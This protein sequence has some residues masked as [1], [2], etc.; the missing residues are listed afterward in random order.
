MEFHRDVVVVGAGFAGLRALW[1]LREAGYS[2]AVLE[3]S[4]GIG[5]VWYANRYPGA[6][7]DVESFDYSYSFS[8]E[9]QQEWRWSER[10]ATQPEI[11]R[12]I[13]HVADRFDLRR[14]V[15][16]G[17]QVVSATWDE[18]QRR[19]DV[20]TAAGEQWGA[21][22]LVWATGQLSISKAPSF[23]GLDTFAGRI[24]H[25]GHWPKE[26]VELEGRRVGVIGTGSSGMQLIPVAAAEASHLTVFQRTP[27]F[28]VPANNGPITDDVDVVVKRSYGER[29]RAA[30]MSPT[31]L[32]LPVSRQ[33]ALEVSAEERAAHYE[34]AW[35]TAGF[36]F[37]VAYYDLLRDRAANDTAA[38]FIRAKIAAAVEDPATR[39]KLTPSGFPF[40]AKRPSVDSGYYETFN[41]PN[42]TLVDVR[43]DPILRFD[44]DGVWTESGHHDLDVVVM[45][46]GFDALTGPLLRPQIVGRG[47][48][49]LRE[50]WRSGPVS[51]LGLMVD[52]FPNMYV[53]A[54]P[55]SPSLLSNVLLS[56]EVH[57]DWIT[58][59]LVHVGDL[60]GAVIEPTP[61]AVEAWMEHVHECAAETLYPE[62][63]SYYNGDEVEG[64]PRVFMP[65]AGGV[66]RY[67]KRLREVVEGGYAG[68]AIDRPRPTVSAA[69]ATQPLPG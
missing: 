22:Q 39:E 37:A 62:A 1:A 4:D 54:G 33:S 7:C 49:T 9:L 15:H 19:W 5:G 30:Q 42:V 23:E 44:A 10:Y 16:L 56:S 36:G 34:E 38:D 17:R 64:K 21:S 47:G 28:S 53:V 48:V 11:L 55:G 59:L 13:D 57:V 52:Q 14:D 32:S 58:A 3:A 40:A 41:R 63:T 26:G 18:Q 68:F 46:T 29:R 2:V 69:Q 27:N 45:A 60:A 6:R 67:A 31:G 61:E 50:R 35:R 25:T 65:Y 43:T 51:Y 8:E 24:V 12:Y 66:R 20:A